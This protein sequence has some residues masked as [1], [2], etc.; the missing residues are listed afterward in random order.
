MNNRMIM[1]IALS[2]TF[3]FYGLTYLVTKVEGTQSKAVA[4][5]IVEKMAQSANAIDVRIRNV[6]SSASTNAELDLLIG[7]QDDFGVPTEE[8]PEQGYIE[9]KLNLEGKER[10]LRVN[11][12]Y[13]LENSGFLLGRYFTVLNDYEMVVVA[14]TDSVNRASFRDWL[15]LNDDNYLYYEKAL[16]YDDG[17]TLYLVGYINKPLLYNVMY[18]SLFEHR[19]YQVAYLLFLVLISYSLLSNFNNHYIR[20]EERLRDVYRDPLTGLHNR[21]FLDTVNFKGDQILAL[22]S[23]DGY[24]ETTGGKNRRELDGKIK[25]IGKAINL[26]TRKNDVVVRMDAGEFVVLL[27]TIELNAMEEVIRRVNEL[28]DAPHSYGY[29]IYNVKK[30]FE[31]NLRD[32]DHLLFE[33]RR[34][35]ET[36]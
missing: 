5:V 23:I 16:E 9:Y 12:N 6:L 8:M 7:M 36:E 34:K 2:F 18:P 15:K 27:D 33:H 24:E 31:T 17:D 35:K 20:R 4:R 25:S 3:L 13:Y 28:T 29:D 32:I 10:Y 21:F 1:V 30:S 19:A 14:E 11:Y 26:A 22:F